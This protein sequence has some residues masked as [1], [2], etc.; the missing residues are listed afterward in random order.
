MPWT[1]EITYSNGEIVSRNGVMYECI[2]SHFA[3]R[4]MYPET[5][6]RFWRQIPSRSNSQSSA[7]ASISRL[8]ARTE[9]VPRTRI[10]TIERPS[11]RLLTRLDTEY[12][13]LMAEIAELR[14][15]S[16]Y[17][18]SPALT[19]SPTFSW[20]SSAASPGVLPDTD[21][22]VSP[23]L[24]E[25]EGGAESTAMDSSYE[26]KICLQ[27]WQDRKPTAT[28]CGHVFCLRCLER[29]DPRIRWRGSCSVCHEGMSCDC[30]RLPPLYDNY[31]PC[32]IC[33]KP[34]TGALPLFI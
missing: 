25:H 21:T 3:R 33:R 29:L 22:H 12:A 30:I 24:N 14:A 2:G 26:C 11:S 5:T 19:M 34:L 4:G 10:V 13:R 8:L 9:T 16:P 1:P 20:S 32:P 7:N 27:P 28:P 18:S 23:P 6:R 15:F 17:P 31:K